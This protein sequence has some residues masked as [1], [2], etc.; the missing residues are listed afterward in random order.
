MNTRERRAAIKALFLLCTEEEIK[1]ALEWVQKDQPVWFGEDGLR[2]LW[3]SDVG[4][5]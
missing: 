3:C 2:T 4:V 1:N 5:P